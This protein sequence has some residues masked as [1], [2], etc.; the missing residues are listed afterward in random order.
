MRKHKRRTQYGS[1]VIEVDG[2]TLNVKFINETGAI[3]DYFEA[4]YCLT[5]DSVQ[6]ANGNTIGLRVYENVAQL[7]SYIAEPTITVSEVTVYQRSN[8]GSQASSGEI[9]K[10]TS[11]ILNGISSFVG[12]ISKKVFEFFD[13]AMNSSGEL[14]LSK[15]FSRTFVGSM[16]S[17][18]DIL[19]KTLK[20][21]LGDS[22]FSGNASKKTYKF[23]DGFLNSSGILNAV[24]QGTLYTQSLFGNMSSSGELILSKYFFRAF[25]GSMDSSGNIIK[26]TL[27]ILSGLMDSSG[28]ASGVKLGVLYTQSLFGSMD[29]SG[30]ISRKINKILLGSNDFSGDILKKVFVLFSG[31]ENP[32]GVLSFFKSATVLLVGS[33]DSSGNILKKTSKY[34]SGISNFSGSILKKI[35]K[36]FSGISDFIGSVF[37]EVPVETLHGKAKLTVMGRRDRFDI[38]DA[39]RIKIEFKDENGD[40]G[41]PTTVTFKYKVK[42]SGT[43]VSY[44][45]GTDAELVKESTGV[46]IS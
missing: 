20:I 33:F 32:T 11:K 29:S 28:I 17:S 4:E 46:T 26:K 27:K 19:K 31:Q 3:N 9:I 23:L 21:L 38:G 43:P 7:N 34:F 37:G 41:D 24:K 22:N 39:V 14:G 45:Y 6:V 36:F 8:V 5:I 25:A 35:R 1:C 10:K 15:Y 42:R 12:D 2:Y 40:L 44:V 30:D 13:G 18:G 16:D